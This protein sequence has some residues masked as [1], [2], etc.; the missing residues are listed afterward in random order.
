[1]KNFSKIILILLLFGI[2]LPVF[3]I[4]AAGTAIFRLSSAKT[5]YYVG[6]NVYVDVMV[7]PNGESINT[8][9]LISDFSGAGVLQINDFNLGTVWPNLSPGKD[10][11]NTTSHINVGG[12][13]LVDAI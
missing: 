11:N 6:E 5:D 2:L 3:S 1:M 9:R 7:E 13:I 12:F 4:H 10:L 8:V